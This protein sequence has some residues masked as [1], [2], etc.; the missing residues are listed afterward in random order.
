MIK[1]ERKVPIYIRKIEPLLLRR[2]VSNHPSRAKLEDEQAKRTAGYRGEQSLDYYLTLLHDKNYHILNDLRIPHLQKHFFQLD[3]LILST[4]F[5]LHLEVKNISGTLYFD[6]ELH[7]LIRTLEGE[8]MAFPDP[9]V[10][11]R[12]QQE[13]FKSWLFKNKFPFIPLISLIVISNP[14]TIIRSA[15]E[16][17]SRL[18]KVVHA[19]ALPEKIEH[20]E[21]N[22]LKEIL[23]TH[24]LNKL[25]R[26][27]KKEDTPLDPDI[28]KI[29]H[30][31][32]KDILKGVHCPKCFFLPLKKSK[33][34]WH[35]PTCNVFHK[36][37]HIDSLK[38]YAYLFGPTITNQ[39]L[40]DFLQISSESVAKRLLTSL[41]AEQRGDCKGRKY[42]IRI[43]E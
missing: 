3:T 36:H 38:D 18:Q 39:Q 17:R 15:P 26:L 31:D 30:I 12:R 11:I 43:D 2:L 7:Q 20:L 27:L 9:F 19:A 5:I 33:R 13:Q 23:S 34:G 28:L 32:K 1:K 37:A 6:P 21:R 22:H 35:C 25:T 29:F 8:E 41:N 16:S 40:R 10:Q 14:S 4:R 42:V 24:D